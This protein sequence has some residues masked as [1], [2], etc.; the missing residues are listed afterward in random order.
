MK[1][2]NLDFFDELDFGTVYNVENNF[3]TNDSNNLIVDNS[4]E[5]DLFHVKK[6]SGFNE[7]NLMGL[8]IVSLKREREDK[9]VRKWLRSDGREAKIIVTGNEYGVPKM[10]DFDVLLALL[11]IHL[12]NNNY[13]FAK[14]DEHKIDVP[15]KINFSFYE[16]SKELGMKI[17]G[18]NYNK[19][20]ERIRRLIDV[21]IETSLM[22]RELSDDDG[23]FD[24]KENTIFGILE[25]YNIVTKEY[26]D[27][28]NKKYDPT[29]IK[30][31]QYVRISDFVVKNICSKYFK[32]YNEKEYKN[33]ST[34]VGKRLYLILNSWS[35]SSLK[36]ISYDVLMNYVGFSEEEKINKRKE[37]IRKIKDGFKELIKIGFID[38]IEVRKGE[39]INIIY[40]V[41]QVENKYKKDKYKSKVEIVAW[42]RSLNIDPRFEFEEILD[43]LDKNNLDYLKGF[44]RYIDFMLNKN[45]KINNLKDYVLR[46]LCYKDVINEKYNVSKFID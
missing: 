20:E 24:L 35:K 5:K 18:T 32:L 10:L 16:L 17:S 15:N 43:I 27:V 37:S 3:K 23:T 11:R 1:S 33:L 38:D 29:K 9:I 39:G 42:F 4:V 6:G 2:E 21:K 41:K 31:K 25:E 28:N 26:F 8:P 12:K 19:L 14:I 13:K 46:G 36:F 22:A 44:A 30:D 45:S 40:N 7:T 34:S